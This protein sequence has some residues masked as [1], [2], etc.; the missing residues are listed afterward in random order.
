MEKRKRRRKIQLTE[1]KL[2]D[3]V[4]LQKWINDKVYN[5]KASSASVNSMLDMCRGI[6]HECCEFEDELNW[7]WWK[8]GD[9]DYEKAKGEWVDIMLFA[10][11]LGTMLELDANEMYRI[12]LEKSKVNIQRQVKGY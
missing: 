4:E 9:I 10:I 7:K 6:I 8:K 2:E 3:I 12:M 5:R 1:D 11:G